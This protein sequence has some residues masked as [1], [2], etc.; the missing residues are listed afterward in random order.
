MS[1]IRDLES[2]VDKI[3]DLNYIDFY[4]VQ[5]LERLID[6]LDGRL[7]DNK[8]QTRT[9]KQGF[10]SQNA[11]LEKIKS[12]ENEIYTLKVCVGGILGNGILCIAELTSD[13]F[14]SRTRSWYWRNWR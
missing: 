11:Q 10:L 1:Y 6:D 12:M 7:T 3:E 13:D 8:I 2:K 5:K 14:R 4:E 9:L